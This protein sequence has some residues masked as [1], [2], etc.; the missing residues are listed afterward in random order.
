MNNQ[1]NLQKPLQ[2]FQS[3]TIVHTKFAA[4]YSIVHSNLYKTDSF[5]VKKTVRLMQVS[6]LSRFPYF[7]M[8]LG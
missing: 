2:A 4:L 1:I 7:C 3:F 6:I 8:F 5:G